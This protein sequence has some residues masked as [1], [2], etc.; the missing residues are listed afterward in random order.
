MIQYEN[1]LAKFPKEL[2]SLNK[3]NYDFRKMS[4]MGNP[5]IDLFKNNTPIGVEQPF[6]YILQ[7]LIRRKCKYRETIRCS[8]VYNT[9]TSC[10][11]IT[12]KYRKIK[13]YPICI[14]VPIDRESVI[15]PLE[16]HVSLFDQGSSVDIITT[17]GFTHPNIKTY[18]SHLENELSNAVKK[19][20]GGKKKGLLMWRRWYDRSQHSHTFTVGASENSIRLN[21]SI[22]YGTLETMVQKVKIK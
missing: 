18:I 21:T 11:E 19:L 2:K 13:E 10:I 9:A 15:N 5:S 12:K 17:N 14:D 3:G 4:H 6:E 8:V 22:P 20:V 7:A 16:V 1:L